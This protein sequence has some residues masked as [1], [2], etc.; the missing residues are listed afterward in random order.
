M[1]MLNI[2]M[3]PDNNNPQSSNPNIDKLEEDLDRLTKE[4]AATSQPETVPPLQSQPLPQPQPLEVPSAPTENIVTPVQPIET[5]PAPPNVPVEGVKKGISLMTVAIALLIVAV[6]VA[7]GYI[8][9]TKF[10]TPAAPAIVVPV[11]TQIPIEVP[12]PVITPQAS[13]SAIPN[14][15]ANYT[16]TTLG[17]SLT[18]PDSW[19]DKY[20][21]IQITP[22]SVEF[23]MKDTTEK[24]PIFTIST[25]SDIEWSEAQSKPHGEIIVRNA[26]TQKVYIKNVA[27][28]NPFTDTTQAENFTLM[29][30]NVK[31][32]LSTFQLLSAT[33]SATPQ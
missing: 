19:K 18:F 24:A 10:M 33:P 29:L 27:L 16:N 30:G 28:E 12:L 5:P 26:S 21:A 23:I 11:Q 13:N 15:T 4:A 6:V 32:I 9:Y 8:G 17:F 1:L 31:S 20:S 22:S 2:I 14:T 25:M 3:N 7:V